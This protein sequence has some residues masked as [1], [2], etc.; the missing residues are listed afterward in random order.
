LGLAA[1]CAGYVIVALKSGVAPD[2]IFWYRREKTP[3]LYWAQLGMF[4]FMG[5]VLVVAVAVS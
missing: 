4:A 3:W 1:C 5:I 2:T